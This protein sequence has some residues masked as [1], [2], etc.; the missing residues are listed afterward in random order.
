MENK[1]MNNNN[2]NNYKGLS[3]PHII[4]IIFV[5]GKILGLVNFNWFICFLPSIIYITISLI[6]TLVLFILYILANK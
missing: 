4:T 3:I 5:I 2:N 1:I 6:I